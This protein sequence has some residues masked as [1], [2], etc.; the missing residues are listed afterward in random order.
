MLSDW[1]QETQTPMAVRDEY[2]FTSD[3]YKAEV[4]RISWKLIPTIF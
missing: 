3:S 2:E 1:L 4:S